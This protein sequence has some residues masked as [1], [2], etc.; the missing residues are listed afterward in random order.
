MVW[1][2]NKVDARATADQGERYVAELVARLVAVDDP[3]RLAELG[4]HA[5]ARLGH[6][7]N[8]AEHQDQHEE[9]DDR[10]GDRMAANRFHQRAPP[11]G[12]LRRISFS[13]R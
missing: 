4:D 8:A 13:G 5:L 2:E 12:W 9:A 3:D 10:G 1:L 7:R 6:D 11:C